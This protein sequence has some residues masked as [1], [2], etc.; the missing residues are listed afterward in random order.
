MKPTDNKKPLGMGILKRLN[1][2]FYCLPDKVNYATSKGF[3]PQFRRTITP[4]F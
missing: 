2:Q 3:T 1:K 4:I